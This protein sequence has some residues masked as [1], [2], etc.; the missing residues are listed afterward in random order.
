MSAE[1]NL[2][3]TMVFGQNMKNSILAK[4]DSIENGTSKGAERCKFQPPSTFQ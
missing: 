4:K 3:Q 1:I 2:V